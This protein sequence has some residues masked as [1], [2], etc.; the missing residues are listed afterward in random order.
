MEWTPDN[1]L[2]M[3]TTHRRENFD[4]PMRNMFRVIGR[5]IDEKQNIKAIYPIHM[6]P[7]V[8]EVA[9]EILDYTDRIRIIDLLEVSD[10]RNF[11]SRSH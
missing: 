11:L 1:K 3:I 8:R 10:F 7:V 9:Q 4:E 5:I 6:N 2:V